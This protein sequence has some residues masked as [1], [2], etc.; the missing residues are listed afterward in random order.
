M[1]AT[2]APPADSETFETFMAKS[3]ADIPDS[4]A[5]VDPTTERSVDVLP[6]QPQPDPGSTDE[7]IPEPEVPVEPAKPEV[8]KKAEEPEIDTTL[9]DRLS[10]LLSGKKEEP[11]AEV[12][13]EPEVEEPAPPGSSPAAQSAW[14]EM[15]Q[16]KKWRKEYEPKLAELTKEVETLRTSKPAEPEEIV[17]TRAELERLKSE[18]EGYIQQLEISR[19]EGTPEFN[20]FVI[21]PIQAIVDRAQALAKRYEVSER[22]VVS[23]LSEFDSAKQSELLTELAANMNEY[24]KVALFTMG[25]RLV[26]LERNGAYIRQN[27]HVALASLDKSKAAQ[28]EIDQKRAAVE[29]DGT[30]QAIGTDFRAKLPLMQKIEGQKEWNDGIESIEQNAR[31]T[32]W[33]DLESPRRAQLIY[34][35]LLLPRSLT[36]LQKL[37]LENQAFKQRLN[38]IRKVS[39]G[40]GDPTPVPTAAIDA[41][42]GFLEAIA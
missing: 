16:H 17:Q 32:K 18:N 15:R 26:E 40:G 5:V 34:Q 12:A 41:N 28:A 23:A 14:A 30:L 13:A 27:A 10:E 3:F 29:W 39:P 7:A 36:L 19:V 20:Q 35:A 9:T 8:A 33:E 42:L 22:D 11:K 37:V 1:P 4:V 25:D 38:G 6:Q 2:E 24:D 31:S 21:Q